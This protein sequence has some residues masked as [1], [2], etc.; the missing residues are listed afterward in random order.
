MNFR[1]DLILAEEQRSAS[2]LNPKSILRIVAIVVP[3][4]IGLLIAKFAFG[5]FILG[6]EV[7][8]EEEKWTSLEP[9]SKRAAQVRDAL[10]A[11][12]DIVSELT[13]WKE[14]HINWHEQLAA[15]QAAVPSNVQL[16][17]FSVQQSLLSDP[18]PSRSFQLQL[19]GRSIADPNGTRVVQ[20][21]SAFAESPPLKSAVKSAKVA[22]GSFLPDPSPQAAK[23]DRVFKIECT[24]TERVFK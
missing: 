15:L 19:A 20:L 2:I 8:R 21:E 10:N 7:A 9:K 24:Y 3:S 4:A 5:V 23:D 11:N 18:A 12:L 16:T 22:A 13:G 1:V 14:T 17:A 6:S